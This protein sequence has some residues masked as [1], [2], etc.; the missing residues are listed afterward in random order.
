MYLLRFKNNNNNKSLLNFRMVF[1]ELCLELLD[2]QGML[3]L[4]GG[5]P[6]G[7]EQGTAWHLSD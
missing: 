6:G 3:F 1:W 4:P 7:Q 2:P 5:L